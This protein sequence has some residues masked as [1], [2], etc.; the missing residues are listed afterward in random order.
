MAGQDRRALMRPLRIAMVAP[1]WASVPPATYGGTELMVHLLTEEL[2]QRGHAVTLFAAGSSRTRATLRSVAHGTVSEAMA[3]GAAHE[4]DHYATAL[5][6]EALRQEAEFDVIHC[7]LGCRFVPMGLVSTMPVLHTT[8]IVLSVDDQWI[9]GRYPQ[10]PIAAI[11]HYQAAAI[12]PQCL[13]NVRLIDHAI[14]FGAKG[15]ALCP[16]NQSAF[17]GRRGP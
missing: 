3:Q 8:H 13:I 17:G 7:H 10:T 14:D 1:L 2:V 15:F 9:V 12:P 6:A 4:Y 5:F 16:G 11:S